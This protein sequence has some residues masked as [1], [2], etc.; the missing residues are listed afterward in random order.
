MDH[1]LSSCPFSSCFSVRVAITTLLFGE[2]PSMTKVNLSLDV[3]ILPRTSESPGLKS[4]YSY[5]SFSTCTS[6]R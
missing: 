2:G 3:Q 4:Y 5:P 1:S 6:L